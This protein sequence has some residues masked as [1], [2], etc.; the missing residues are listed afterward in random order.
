MKG[1]VLM[2][3]L[4]DILGIVATITYI[5]I[6]I[7]LCSY[8]LIYVSRSTC[9]QAHPCLVWFVSLFSICWPIVLLVLLGLI[10]LILFCAIFALGLLFILI[11]IY[12]ITY[13]VAVLWSY[14]NKK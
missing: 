11:P 9:K 10:A 4:E 13:V 7:G 6:A 2:E 8:T 12:A 5:G 14:V 3:I 1:L